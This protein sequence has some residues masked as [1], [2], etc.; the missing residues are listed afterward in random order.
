MWQSDGDWDCIAVPGSKCRTRRR[1]AINPL[2]FLIL[3][4]HVG[5]LASFNLKSVEPC[6]YIIQFGD[7]KIQEFLSKKI[8]GYIAIQ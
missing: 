8:N 4:R 3:P 2:E 6:F 5:E 7:E 1:R